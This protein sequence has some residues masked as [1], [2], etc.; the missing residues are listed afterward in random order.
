M[1][2]SNKGKLVLVTGGT[3]FVGS[4]CIAKL[5][6]DGYSVRTTIRTLNRKDEVIEMLRN[7]GIT[8]FENLSFVETDLMSDTNWNVAVNGCEYVL[9]VASPISLS[10][11]K[12]ESIFIKPAVEGT[13]RVLKAARDNGVKRVVFTSSLG[14]I[15]YGHPPTER[16]FTEEDWTNIEN[17]NLSAYVKSKTMAEKAAWKFMSEEGG[18][19]EFSVINPAGIFGPTLTPILTTGFQIIKGLLDGSTKATPNVKF[20]IVDVRDLADLHIIAMQHPL[21]KGQRFIA[22]IGVTLSLHE[23]AMIL[24]KNMGGK[25]KR[26]TTKI[27][28]DWVIRVA[29]PFSALAKNL[30]PQLNEIKNVNSEKAKRI[31]GWKPMTNEEAILAS[32]ESLYKLNLIKN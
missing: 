17:K 16:P 2:N 25:G 4:H 32:A 7:G 9:H 30:A 31:L 3:G 11:P 12:D 22:Q 18:N 10:N 14:A 21:A 24:R 26:V 5:L 6:Q 1:E 20:G 19:L 27:L 8:S 28:P 29:S 23:I 15:Y 13:I